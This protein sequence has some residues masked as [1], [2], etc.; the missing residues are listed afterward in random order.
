MKIIRQIGPVLTAVILSACA[1]T[2]PS[3]AVASQPSFAAEASEFRQ[4]LEETVADLESRRVQ[5]VVDLPVADVR[6]AVSMPIP[7]HPSVSSAL[8]LFTGRMR[9]DI[10]TYLLRSAR[11]KNLIDRVLDE[12]RLPRGLAYLPVIESGYGPTLT[13]RAGAHG[14]WQ[15]M[16]D[17]AREYGMRV[18]WWVDERAEAERSTRAAA[19]F[20]V[21]LHR[22]F[23]DW[24]LALA[25]YNAGPGRIRRALAN[26]GATTFWELLEM[27]AIPKET[28]GYVPT[29]FATLIIATDPDTYGFRL[30]QPVDPDTRR[31]E[32]AGPV[33]LR[34][35]AEVAQIEESRLRA[36]NPG[37]RR[38]V[39]PPGRWPV[40]VPANHTPAIAERASTLRSEDPM[41]EICSY[42]LRRGDTVKRLAKAIGAT[43]ETILAMNE[44]RDQAD[45]R[46]G[47]VIYLPVRA[48]ELASMLSGS[49]DKRT[50]YA[51][52]K[53]DTLYSIAK[54]Y[55]LTV[56]EL[57]DLNELKKGQP[58]RTGQRLRISAPRPLTAGGM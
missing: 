16:P 39:V 47:Q 17:T 57:R 27:S 36:L 45:L 28:R 1:S 26:T 53:G 24:P 37:L 30:D 19:E 21:D 56:D 50:Y 52:R 35:V 55:N 23:N 11:Y 20:L 48:R 46:A 5:P 34:Y 54:K 18:D 38:G 4:A 7:D 43:P 12:H 33:S 40:T 8:T 49:G 42:T 25:A 15:F 51:V 44:A 31:I 22:E 6:A 14:I 10:Q 32:L 2:P 58:L 9:N 13:S 41:I 3:P 29:F